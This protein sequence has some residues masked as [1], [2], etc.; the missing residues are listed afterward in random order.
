MIVLFAILNFS[1]WCLYEIWQTIKSDA[2]RLTV[3]AN[4]DAFKLRQKFYD[5]NFK[6]AEASMVADRDKILAEIQKT[7]PLDRLTEVIKERIVESTYLDSEKNSSSDTMLKYALMLEC[8]KRYL[9]ASEIYQRAIYLEEL[10][11]SPN[12]YKIAACQDVLANLLDEMNRFDDALLLFKKALDNYKTLNAIKKTA[13]IKSIF[14]ILVQINIKAKNYYEERLDQECLSLIKSLINKSSIPILLQIVE[15]TVDSVSIEPLSIVQFT[16]NLATEIC[17]AD[18]IYTARSMNILAGVLSNAGNHSEALNL[19]KKSLEIEIK[20]R[21]VGSLA[22]SI[23]QS[24][25]AV[26][27]AN[28]KRYSESLQIHRITAITREKILGVEHKET[29]IAYNNLAAGLRQIGEYK[30]AEKLYLKILAINEKNLGPIHETT[31]NTCNNLATLYMYMADLYTMNGP[32][33][34][35]KQAAKLYER[36]FEERQKTLGTEHPY[37]AM[38]RDGLAQVYLKFRKFNEALVLAKQSLAIN[39][40]VLGY[41]HPNTASSLSMLA[42]VLTGLHHYSEAIPLL[43]RSIGILQKLHG[44][45]H[46]NIVRCLLTLAKI[47]LDMENYSIVIPLLVKTISMSLNIEG[48]H[49]T[50]L[51][52]INCLLEIRV[53]KDYSN[54]NIVV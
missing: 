22:V 1:V 28:L 54:I 40:K 9:D 32:N 49:S 39:E 15:Q 38:S 12:I 27:L 31:I 52:A 30:E 51:A 20:E 53:P 8:Q 6:Q 16:Y 37:T 50:T 45:E 7:T 43:K 34:Y 36:A 44:P 48:N 25:L 35:V 26:V 14:S 18:S 3:L 5:F 17:G 47:Q 10:K 42:C 2:S 33:I 46:F 41:H 19:Y 29:L 24:N 13:D 11:I 21:G 23:V 4:I